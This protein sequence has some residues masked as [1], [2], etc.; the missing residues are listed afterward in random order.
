MTILKRQVVGIMGSGTDP[1][2]ELAIPLATWIA[3]QNYHLL[4]GAGEGVM[5]AAS[6]AF[7]EVENRQGICIGIVPTEQNNE[8]QFVAKT[9]YPNPWVE[10]SITSPLPTFQGANKKQVSRNHICVL[11]SDVIVALPGNKGTRNE[12]MLAQKFHKP[13]ILFGWKNIIRDLPRTIERTSDLER[14][15]SFICSHLE[16]CHGANAANPNQLHNQGHNEE[17]PTKQN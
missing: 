10:L 11:S 8:G 14:V 7:C 17:N 4:T 12:V 16:T 5:T 15:Q 1:Q 9:G 6:K 13:I 3:E 2:P